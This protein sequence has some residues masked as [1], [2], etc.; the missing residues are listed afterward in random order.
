[1]LNIGIVDD[2]AIII[3]GYK[4]LIELESNLTV[5]GAYGSYDEAIA[6]LSQQS[7]HILIVDIL[8]PQK[9]GLELIKQVN[10][11]YPK[12][13]M[14][15]V[16]MYDNE[17]YVSEAIR[18]G[19]LG[20]LSKHR[21]SDELII[22]I[23]HVCNDETYYSQDVAINVQQNKLSKS[24]SKLAH[25]TEREVEILKLLAR[26]LSIKLIASNLDIQPKT[27]HAHKANIFNKL[28]ISSRS[29]LLQFA[30][31]QRILCLE[32]LTTSS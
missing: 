21:V 3:D 25:L 6:G 20:Y 13:R 19:A 5:V 18:N 11:S 27:V 15:A 31:S 16:S 10:I 7:F 29:S 17:P 4:R 8:L 26:G 24:D 14:I 30:L 1:M 23:K 28:D 22:A 2:H 12:T 9:N 32:D